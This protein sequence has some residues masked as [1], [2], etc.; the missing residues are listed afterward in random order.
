[1]V[2][3]LKDAL[4]LP[5]VVPAK[6][7]TA[8]AAPLPPGDD[9]CSCGGLGWLKYDVPFGHPLF[10]QIHPC[11]DCGVALQL[12]WEELSWANRWAPK[13]NGYTFEALL[14]PRDN[15][16]E[17][18][19]LEAAR[20]AAQAFAAHP[21]GFLIFAGGV[22]VAKTH[23]LASIGLAQP[24]GRLWLYT[25]AEHLWQALGC[26]AM[27]EQEKQRQQGEWSARLVK[28]RNLPLLLLDE[29]GGEAERD[30]PAVQS[31]R[32]D[33]LGWRCDHELP[34]AIATNALPVTQLYGS[35]PTY[36]SE[37]LVDRLTDKGFSV[38]VEMP[39]MR[40]FRQVAR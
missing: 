8:V 15:E 34:T 39:G 35:T 1:M 32:M 12:L 7:G 25:S 16:Q 27:T 3:A 38:V 30:T 19:T 2:T 10:G 14:L 26:V 23:L 13:M 36:D 31:K 18:A 40:S 24:H 33:V 20:R 4:H 37:R 11:P 22:G 17:R 29:L 9:G 6:L 28:V 21:R 5:G